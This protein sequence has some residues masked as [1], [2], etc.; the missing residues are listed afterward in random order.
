[1][2]K[3]VK[4]L[5]KPASPMPMVG[6]GL[7]KPVSPKRTCDVYSSNPTPLSVP[8]G[9]RPIKTARKPAQALPIKKR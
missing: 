2:Q 7:G 9:C 4:K 3:L 1:M 5:D 6:K 8:E